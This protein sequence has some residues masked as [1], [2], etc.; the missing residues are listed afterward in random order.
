MYLNDKQITFFKCMKRAQDIETEAEAF[1]QISFYHVKESMH[2]GI[3]E[4]YNQIRNKILLS[5][6]T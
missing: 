2:S 4:T 6:T 5:E 1:K 3:L